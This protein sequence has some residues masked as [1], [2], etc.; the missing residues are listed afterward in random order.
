[1]TQPLQP[2]ASVLV[3]RAFRLASLATTLLLAGC[4]GG[5][6]EPV[7]VSG[8]YELQTING[9]PL[10][11]TFTNGVVVTK[12]VLTVKADGTFTD[13]TTQGS[14]TVVADAGLY[15]NFGGTVNFS[16]QTAGFVYQ[17]FVSG[18]QLTTKVGS[19]TSVFLRTGP[20]PQ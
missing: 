8:I 14:G 7:S 5:S 9:A 18:N 15:S 19:F 11:F 4:L 1:M 20:A 12:E 17:A 16:D 6:T 10:P 2:T 3:R 13:V